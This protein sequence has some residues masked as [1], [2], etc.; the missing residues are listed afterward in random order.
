MEKTKKQIADEMA[1][2]VTPKLQDHVKALD[3]IRRERAGIEKQLKELEDRAAG[4]QA[5][6]LQA[7]AKVSETILANGNPGAHLRQVELR[8][9][10]IDAFGRQAEKLRRDDAEL[11]KKEKAALKALE[12]VLWASLL[13]YRNVLEEKVKALLDE[14][15]ALMMAYEAQAFCEYERLGLLEFISA[16]HQQNI[17]RFL[18]C[19][20]LPDLIEPFVEPIGAQASY[21]GRKE[22]RAKLETA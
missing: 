9:A 21:I 6:L 7:E 14:A 17:G 1:V 3:K 15:L 16:E 11:E 8:R 2:Y 12:N 5:A 10:E 22:V 19:T 13:E 20:G 18:R 4:S